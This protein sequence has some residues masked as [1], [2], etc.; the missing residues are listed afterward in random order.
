[1]RDIKKLSRE[2]ILAMLCA[3]GETDEPEESDFIEGDEEAEATF[4]KNWI[5]KELN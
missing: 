4:V 1:M 2:E 3:P 5:D